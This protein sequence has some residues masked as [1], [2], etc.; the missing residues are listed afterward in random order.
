MTTPSSK[1]RPHGE[2]FEPVPTR[3]S[4]VR[5]AHEAR[6]Q[7][8]LRDAWVNEVFR[9]M[10]RTLT[11]LHGPLV[12]DEIAAAE[13]ERLLANFEAI[14]T[15]WTPAGYVRQRLN[16]DRAFIDHRRRDNEIGRA[17]V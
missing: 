3:G 10:C 13:V 5:R 1:P 9:R 8:A 16:G 6:R 14:S 17:H 7:E 2:F 4:A 11:I 12:A 15:R